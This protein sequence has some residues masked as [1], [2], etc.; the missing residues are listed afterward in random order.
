MENILV[1]DS[2]IGG[3]YTAKILKEKYPSFNYIYFKDTFNC[4]YGNKSKEELLKIAQNN[5]NFVLK[6]YKI[7]AVVLACNTLS[8][9]CVKELKKAY[10]LPF[11]TVE[12]PINKITKPCVVLCTQTCF[13]AIK[14]GLV[15]EQIEYKELTTFNTNIN[16][17]NLL[18]CAMHNLAHIIEKDMCTKEMM[19]IYLKNILKPVKTENY[20]QLLIGCTHYNFVVN[21]LQTLFNGYEILEGSEFVSLNN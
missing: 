17:I 19:K 11:F 16:S 18:F 21:Q 2:G 13:L 7:R 5:I 4:P 20:N 3:L 1:L 9:N 14:N 6:R 12:P 10:N 8:T 15:G